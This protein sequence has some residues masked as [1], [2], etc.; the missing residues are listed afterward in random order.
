MVTLQ[1]NKNGFRLP[2]EAEWEYAAKAGQSTIYSGG[3]DL[4]ELGWYDDN[5]LNNGVQR[6]HPV[7]QKK[8]NPWGFYDLSGNVWEWCWDWYDVRLS[9]KKLTT[10]GHEGSYRVSVADRGDLRDGCE[11]HESRIFRFIGFASCQQRS[12]LS[13]LPFYKVGA[14]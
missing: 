13:F 7:E 2:T 5:S 1:E 10:K 14:L 9:R 11:S 3:N 12:L 6:T 4:A 8:K